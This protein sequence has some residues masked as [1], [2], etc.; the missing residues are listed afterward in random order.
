M[1]CSRLRLR[2]G[3]AMVLFAVSCGDETCKP[4]P[5]LSSDSGGLI[6]DDDARSQTQADGS[7]YTDS[8]GSELLPDV[9]GWELGNICE[10]EPGSLACP[11]QGNQDC[12]SGYCVPATGGSVCT[13]T[14]LEECPFDWTCTGVKGFGADLV[15]LC[16]PEAMAGCGSGQDAGLMYSCSATWPPDPAPGEAFI[17]C[18]G[19]MECLDGGW[20]DCIL[21]A[22]ECDGLDNNCDGQIDEGFVDESGTYNTPEHCG[23]CNRNCVLLD[24]PNADTSCNTDLETPTC[25]MACED[26]FFDLN[27]NPEDGCECE[28][29]SDT[30]FP[31]GIDQNCDGVD[32]EVDAAIYVAKNGDDDASGTLL[33][34]MLTIQA[35]LDRAKED[36]KR[37]VYVA[38]GV[39]AETVEL[40]EGVGLYGGYSSDFKQRNID[41]NVTVIMGQEVSTAKPAAVNAADI[42]GKAGATVLDGFTIFGRNNMAP[43]GST[44][45]IYAR[46]CSDGLRV[47]H[48]TIEAGAAGSGNKGADGTNGAG[49]AEGEDGAVAFGV[50]TDNCGNIVPALPRPGGAGGAALCG[51]EA[52]TQGGAGGGNTCPKTYGIGPVDYENGEPGGGTG[53][54]AGGAGGYDREIWYCVV[55]PSGECHQASGGKETGNPGSSGSSGSDGITPGS[56]GCLANSAGGWVLGG[57]WKGGSGLGGE[58]GADG[59]GGGGGGAG[60]GAQNG[61]GC[62]SRTHVGGT[63]GGGGSGGCGGSGGKTGGAGGGSFGVFVVWDEEPVTIPVLTDNHIMGGVGGQGGQGG[64]AGSGGPG[65][66]G[67]LGGGDDFANAP[68]S[69]PGSNGGAGGHGGHGEGGGGGCGG[70]SYCVFVHG[71]GSANVSAYTGEN[72]CVVGAGGNGGSGGPSIGNPGGKGANGVADASNF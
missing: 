72:S 52:P 32:G 21:P 19:F 39:Y 14:C 18:Y 33:D 6:Q 4:E 40:K 42:E 10:S 65:G 24:Y 11:C 25:V 22:E 46:N 16:L 62:G 27:I 36:G 15:F 49:G 28:F 61:P 13:M 26:G 38:T 51:D 48:N 7:A 17:A 60:G 53:G 43:G 66:A 63:G 64:N 47:S 57:L 3:L 9:A 30:D 23:K 71:G 59:S 41:L 45:G 44:Y 69:A 31:D 68:C 50:N 35:A 55:F 67:G 12:L 2:V 8:R 20:S 34:P 54:G 58:S 70:A 37:D 29:I 56:N 1:A 5:S